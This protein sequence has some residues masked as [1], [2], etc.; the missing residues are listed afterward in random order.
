[1]LM[2]SGE[3]LVLA[4]SLL[5]FSFALCATPKQL[6]PAEKL[7]AFLQNATASLEA[8]Y[9]AHAINSSVWSSDRPLRAQ[10]RKLLWQAIFENRNLT[11]GVSGESHSQG[12]GASKSEFIYVNL[13]SSWLTQAVRVYGNSSAN[14]L[15]VNQGVSGAS[16]M[17]AAFCLEAFFG[18][19]IDILWW[20]FVTNDYQ[21]FRTFSPASARMARQDMLS[22]W[23]YRA[24]LQYSNMRDIEYIGCRMKQQ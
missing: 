4:I 19:K 20:E 9:G 22:L 16:T 5:G 8:Q 13:V 18:K 2:R 21:H 11:I 6:A 7:I 23:A 15:F 10:T 12:T 17:S 3:I 24:H 14:I 1:M